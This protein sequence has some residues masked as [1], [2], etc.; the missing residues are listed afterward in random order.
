MWPQM[1]IG[2]QRR[3]APPC[4]HTTSCHCFQA[5]T[6]N[7]GQPPHQ[8]PFE[9]CAILGSRGGC[10]SDPRAGPFFR[11]N[12]IAR[13]GRMAPRV[14]ICGGSACSKKPKKTKALIKSIQDVA[15]IEEVGCQDICRGPVVGATVKGRLEWFRRLD[16]KNSRKA[17]VKLATRGKLS[18]PLKKRRV[19]KL[20]GRLR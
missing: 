2:R 19:K 10:V 15:S 11:R 12:T 1:S 16:T 18:Q 6:W 13:G 14:F 20:A 7:E 3:P 9:S 8:G 4:C 17:L 5:N